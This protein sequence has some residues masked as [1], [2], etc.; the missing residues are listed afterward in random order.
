MVR[1]RIDRQHYH[2]AVEGRDK[3]S[4]CKTVTT[5]VKTGM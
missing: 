3:T 5:A 4:R 1:T 2:I